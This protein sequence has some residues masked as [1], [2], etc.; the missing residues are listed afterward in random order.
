M[1]LLWLDTL[2]SSM[3]GRHTEWHAQEARRIRSV[4]WT[5]RLPDQRNCD[6]T[7]CHFL[8]LVTSVIYISDCCVFVLECVL[9]YDTTGWHLLYSIYFLSCNVCFIWVRASYAF[10]VSDSKAAFTFEALPRFAGWKHP[11]ILILLVS[12]LHYIIGRQ[13]ISPNV[14]SYQLPHE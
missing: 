6:A 3:L 11:F 13:E 9:F 12:L 8:S 14:K 10:H 4:L 1:A 2:W 5:H 7:A